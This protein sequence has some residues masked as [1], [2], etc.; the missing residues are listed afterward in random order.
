M[1]PNAE[2]FY[3]PSGS[4]AVAE[5]PAPQSSSNNSAAKPPKDT[6]FSWTASEYIDHDRGASWYL[7][8]I[9]GT[10]LLAAGTYLLT[11]EYFATGTIVAVGIIVG[12]YSRQKP[13]QVTYELSES[14]LRIGE[15]SY[16][17]NLF[18][19]FALVKDGML[20]SIQL[21]PLKRFMPP[22]SAYYDAADEEKITDILGEHLPYE[23]AKPDRI[24]SLS[25]RL[26]F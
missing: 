6:S 25:R 22:I 7:L 12:I 9:I 23:D 20:N 13:R 3:K 21:S 14:S 24:E 18:K 1:E 8:L 26:K 15:K 5:A 19:S 2:D 17:Y 16:S 11:K 10:A 4:A